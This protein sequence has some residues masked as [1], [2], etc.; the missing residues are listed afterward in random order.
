MG[1][2]VR[3]TGRRASCR[4]IRIALYAEQRV[5]DTLDSI[6]GIAY[7]QEVLTNGNAKTR[8]LPCPRPSSVRSYTRLDQTRE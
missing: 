4:F 6:H 5:H 1:P 2:V 8:L 3:S 7:Q